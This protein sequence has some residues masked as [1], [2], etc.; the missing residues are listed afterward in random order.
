[1]KKENVIKEYVR[2]MNNGTQHFNVCTYFAGGR[3]KPGGAYDLKITFNNKHRAR[4]NLLLR[5][6]SENNIT[7]KKTDAATLATVV[8]ID[9]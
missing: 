5:V 3:N 7:I 6:C 4:Y 1:M 8:F 9:E 2:D